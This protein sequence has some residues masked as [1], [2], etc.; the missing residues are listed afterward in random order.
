MQR[1][2]VAPT[3]LK[4][5]HRLS[6]VFAK[7]VSSLLLDVKSWVVAFKYHKLNVITRR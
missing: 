4:E 7:Y 5:L 1:E 3:R 6:Y 2:C